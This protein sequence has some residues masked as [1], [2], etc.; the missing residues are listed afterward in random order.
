MINVIVNKNKYSFEKGSNLE[1]I[2]KKISPDDKNIIVAA[3]VD[4]KI[5]ELNY[6]I[7]EDCK[8]D[9]LDI[10]NVLG[11]RIYRRSLFL[12][13][14]K[15]I[16]QIFPGSRLFI[17]HSLSNGIYCELYK[18][19][20]ILTGNN[21]REIYS[22]MKK[23]VKKE[24]PIKKHRLKKEE[25]VSIYKKQGFYDRIDVIKDLN[26]DYFTIYELDGYY[27]YFFYHMVP[28]T[29][30]LKEFDLHYS[31][32]GFILLFPQKKDP[33][34][35]ADFKEQAK[36][37]SVFMEYEKL[38]NILEV[39]SVKE[40]N[41]AIKNMN[42]RELI[43]IC[44]GLHE[45]NV[46]LIAD[47][48]YNNISEKQIILIAGPS[49]SGKTT[50]TRRLSTQLKVN[51]LKPVAI[52]VDDYFVS[53]E[54]TPRD[55]NGD[56]DFEA[57]EAIDLELFNNHLIRLLQNQRVEIPRFNF[58]TGKREYT[59]EYLKLKNNQP[60]LIEG[61]H[62]LNDKLTRVIPADH[63]FKIYVSALTQ[64]NIDRHNRIPTTDTR[65]IRRIVRD[66]HFRGHNAAKT[67]TWWPS[68]RK[69]EEENIFPYQ[70]NADVMFNSALIYELAVLKNYAV[71]L[72]KK[73]EK[74]HEIYYEAQRLL[75]ILE[76][77]RPMPAE[78]IPN[79]SILREFI[80]GSVFR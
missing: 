12:L 68:V 48:I 30:Y 80:G 34:N 25:V 27:D 66:H 38:G 60:L 73:I 1:N 11:N 67:I 21:I 5:R 64:L 76:Y 6:K 62:G 58:K 13:M 53:R 35:V 40:L 29:D 46:A 44:E 24:L 19:G 69:G 8:V 23:L 49:S 17:E 26:R 16:Y 39:A 59:G 63:K 77:F 79:T 7:K 2:I 14:A 55:K 37:A 65:V 32:P 36:L 50:F 33:Y 41:K 71:P 78:D 22:Y 3:I 51:G 74:D 56:Y 9:F 61:I 15:A 42:Y 43:R 52:S 75:E 28:G 47:Q 45:K 31:Y 72:L 10:S 4:N 20:G 18:T 70:E 54:D 57:L